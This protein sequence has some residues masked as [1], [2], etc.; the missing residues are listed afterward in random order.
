M[1][2]EQLLNEIP[3]EKLKSVYENACNYD[4]FFIKSNTNDVYIAYIA[5]YAY[6]S[7]NINFSNF[8]TQ[9][10]NKFI[11]C[12]FHGYSFLTENIIKPANIRTNI[13]ELVENKQLTWLEG[14]KRLYTTKE[15]QVFGW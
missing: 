14:L 9:I 5:N 4:D 15:L 7:N 6:H 1:S 11:K 12:N 3:Y 10:N 8:I 2:K 13:I